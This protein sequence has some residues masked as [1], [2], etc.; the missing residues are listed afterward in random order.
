MAVVGGSPAGLEAAR[1]A[2]ERR[3][4]VVLF[5]G[6]PRLGG[7]ARMGARGSRR[8]DLIGLVEW[9]ERELERLGVEICLNRFAEPADVLREAPDLVVIATGDVP[10]IDWI[11]G[12]AHC[13]SVWDAL[14]GGAPLGQEIIV[15]D[16]TGRHPAPLL[17][18]AA[19]GQ[20]R[21]VTVV[22]IDSQLAQ[23]LTYAERV[24]WKREFYRP[25]VPIIFDHRIERVERVGNRISATFRNLVTDDPLRLTGDQVIVEHGTCQPTSST[26]RCGADHPMTG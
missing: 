9:R 20:G 24:I 21:H 14:T 11:H 18:E 2:A 7:Q 5:E 13:T 8:R 1:V 26:T 22:S 6:A 25:H 23:E 15:Y 10:D 16:G 17:V 3:H 4:S 19:T 12:A